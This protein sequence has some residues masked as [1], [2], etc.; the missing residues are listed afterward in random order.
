MLRVRL[1]CLAMLF[2]LKPGGF[3]APLSW[4]EDVGV[5]KDRLVGDEI[6]Q[7]L[8]HDHLWL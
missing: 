8:D 1:F 6:G 3:E 2:W 5:N 7:I 4:E